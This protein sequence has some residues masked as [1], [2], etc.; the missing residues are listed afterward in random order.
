MNFMLIEGPHKLGGLK[1]L[2]FDALRDR[3]SV[4]FSE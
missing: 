4:T 3:V 2:K 1:D